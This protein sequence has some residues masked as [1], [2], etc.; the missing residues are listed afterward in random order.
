MRHIVRSI[1]FCGMLILGMQATAQ[2]PVVDIAA[3]TTINDQVEVFIRPDAFF[4]GYFAAI[5]FTIRWFDDDGATLGS[6]EQDPTIQSYMNVN[7]SGPELVDGLFR[8]Q[9]FAGFG[10]QT[11]SD[12]AQNWSPS[13]EIILCSVNINNGPSLF[14]ISDD[15]FTAG[16]NG[17]FYISLNGSDQT[18]VIYSFTTSTPTTP[19]IP[20]AWLGPNP[21]DGLIWLTLPEDGTAQVEILDAA[22]RLLATQLFNATA[23]APNTVDLSDRANGMYVMRVIQGDLVREERVLLA[24]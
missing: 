3:V 10:A 9:V 8:Y 13:E 23:N 1:C 15:A 20:T 5:V 6:I 14:S 4:D 12:L 7:K 11:L 2:L 17:T 16:Q 24:R 18:G 22:G 19:A 21:T